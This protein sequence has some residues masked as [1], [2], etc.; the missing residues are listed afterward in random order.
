MSKLFEAP[1]KTLEGKTSSLG[2]L[3]GKALLI[4]NVAS[5]CGLTPQYA[6]LEK[7]HEE[8]EKRGFAVVGFPCNQFAGQEPGSSADIRTFCSTKYGVTFPLFEKIEVN[9]E[10]RHPIYQELTKVADAEGEAGDVKWNFEKFV[11]SADGKTVK[12]FRP[13]TQP[14]DP[15]VIAAIEKGLAA[16]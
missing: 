8:Y 1:V 5:Q 16:K 3:K 7:L 9:G 4:V 11:V 10:H 2:S 6:D 13:M 15:A 12:R 14:H